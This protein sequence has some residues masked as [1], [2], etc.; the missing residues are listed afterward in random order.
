MGIN[1]SGQIAA[2][3]FV[4][5]MADAPVEGTLGAIANYSAGTVTYLGGDTQIT[6]FNSSGDAAYI[7]ATSPA[8]GSPEQLKFYNSSTGA[9]TNIT[10][11]GF[12]GLTGGVNDT[13]Q[14]T[15][16][17]FVSAADQQTGYYEGNALNSNLSTDSVPLRQAGAG[18]PEPGTLALLALAAFAVVKMRRRHGALAETA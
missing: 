3:V 16:G 4:G 15:G 12:S 8:Y 9:V 17:L 6:G 13:G 2:N 18:V 10:D 7:Q 14:V 5:G 1:D 11:L